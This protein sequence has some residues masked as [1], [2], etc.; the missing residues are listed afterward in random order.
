LGIH[1]TTPKGILAGQD[2]SFIVG[3]FNSSYS[4]TPANLALLPTT[5]EKIFT[6]CAM[7]GIAV[8]GS[9]EKIEI[10]KNR[11][12]VFNSLQLKK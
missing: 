9:C 5:I 2:L 6:D 3:L 4:D 1:T 11:L 10:L 12:R 8:P 7:D